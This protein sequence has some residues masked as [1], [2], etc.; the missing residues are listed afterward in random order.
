MWTYKGFS[1]VA[2][3]KWAQSRNSLWPLKKNKLLFVENRRQGRNGANLMTET[4]HRIESYSAVM[5]ILFCQIILTSR[6]ILSPLSILSKHIFFVAQRRDGLRLRE[7]PNC[8]KIPFSA[9]WNTIH[10]NIKR[11]INV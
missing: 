11:L 8:L 10:E 3:T 9:V 1:L 2:Q 6:N 7:S 4:C 5:K